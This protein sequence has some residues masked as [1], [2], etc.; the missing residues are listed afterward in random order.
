MEEGL[1]GWGA[2]EGMGGGRLNCWTYT[3]TENSRCSDGYRSEELASVNKSFQWGGGGGATGGVK[4]DPVNFEG[5]LFAWHSSAVSIFGGVGGGV[6]W[7]RHAAEMVNFGRRRRRCQRMQWRRR[8]LRTFCSDDLQ[9]LIPRIHT[10]L[11]RDYTES[12]RVANLRFRV[13][14]SPIPCPPGGTQRPTLSLSP[15]HP[16]PKK[17]RKKS[18][19][20]PL[21]RSNH[22][23]T[24]NSAQSAVSVFVDSSG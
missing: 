19:T 17:P 12:T 5:H 20:D 4:H 6:G 3:N 21:T 9:Q 22:Q 1:G 2:E 16:P 23:L 13:L 18:P 8:L 15:P 14:D 11:H 7:G 24:F 10:C